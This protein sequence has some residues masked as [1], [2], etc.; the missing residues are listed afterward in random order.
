MKSSKSNGCDLVRH[1]KPQMKKS[2]LDVLY[3]I[4]IMPSISARGPVTTLKLSKTL[5]QTHAR[6]KTKQHT[7]LLKTTTHKIHDTKQ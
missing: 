5:K 1:G 4:A 7:M 2:N 3:I 6:D